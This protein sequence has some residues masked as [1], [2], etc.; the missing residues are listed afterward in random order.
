M[1]TVLCRSRRTTGVRRNRELIDTSTEED[2]VEMEERE[3]KRSLGAEV[4]DRDAAE[5]DEFAQFI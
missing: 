5:D 4:E 2:P 1:S 3:V